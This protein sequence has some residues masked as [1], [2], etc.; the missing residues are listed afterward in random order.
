MSDE[1]PAF[2]QGQP[3]APAGAA[4]PQSD[5]GP[6]ADGEGQSAG[7]QDA[8]VASQRTGFASAAAGNPNRS[9]GH[10]GHQY[11]A[12]RQLF[13]D[14]MGGAVLGDNNSINTIY[15]SAT[16][17]KTL[18]HC[19]LSAEALDEA[20]AFV[21]PRDYRRVAGFAAPRP[22]TVLTG[23]E[24]SGREATARH[25]LAAQT[26]R[27]A[28]HVVHPDTDFALLTSQPLPKGVGIVL[29][30]A[31]ARA[32]ASLTEFT[33]RQLV[34][35]L[36]A[37]GQKM[38][39]TAT[40]DLPWGCRAVTAHCVTLGPPP[41]PAAV[42]AAQFRRRFGSADQATARMLLG[43]RDVRDLIAARATA[44]RPMMDAAL[45]ATLLADAAGNPETMAAN[46]ELG[47]KANAAGEIGD[48]FESLADDPRDQYY[49]I[50]LAVLNG[51]P[52]EKVAD[53]GKRLG[54]LLAPETAERRDE[55]RREPFGG[56]RRP[57][58]Q[59]VR[60]IQTS[61]ESS[62]GSDEASELVVRYLNRDY[63]R[64]LLR[65][66]WEEYDEERGALTRWLRE[67]GS[68]ALEDVHIGAGVAAAALAIT[69]YEHVFQT[70]V[71]PWARSR[72]IDQQ[73]AAA[74]AL[75]TIGED[76]RFATRVGRLIE[77]WAQPEAEVSLQVTAAR[78]YGARFGAQRIDE[79]A[80]VLSELAAIQQW[81]VTR[82]VARS[83]TELIATDTP[84]VTAR[85]FNLLGEWVSGRSPYVRS[86]GRLAFL[87][88]A[89][90]LVVRVP[91][92]VSGE[93]AAKW[94]ALLRL[95]L[96]PG[97]SPIIRYL[98][99]NAL[100]SADL[101]EPAR[102]VLTAWAKS[103]E[104]NRRGCEALARMLA[105]AA[106]TDRTRLILHRLAGQWSGRGGGGPAPRAAAILAASAS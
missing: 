95:D 78:S 25:L 54:R 69:S 40:P 65:H 101:H 16:D 87:F 46:A 41:D 22:L 17:R 49:A 94:P 50:A 104:T 11:S 76:P 6:N 102:D 88:A 43:R 38:I 74:V 31:T 29:A 103:L 47:M 24:G 42:V 72:D 53:A 93:R 66:V 60:A 58:L 89:A 8:D 21:A 48:W 39:V 57:R 81:P 20:L 32:A 36:G 28:I 37:A 71:L 67:L 30:D 23:A 75:Q 44:D 9:S 10:L 61:R 97:Y 52:N 77:E 83:L 86:T 56:G 70:I 33:L 80:G 85:V 35:A 1:S 55:Q 59:R 14:V 98:W 64:R 5:Q 12:Q 3:Q 106:S 91:E 26:G 100:N 96:E 18:I 105:G 34:D 62:Q 84:A 92:R 73:D 27:Q 13:G 63:P 99:A 15:L 90:D 82:A 45:L 4:D 7:N 68:S 79:A 51:L 19:A 2:A